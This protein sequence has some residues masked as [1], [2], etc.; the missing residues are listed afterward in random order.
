MGDE[1]EE[2]KLVERNAQGKVKQKVYSCLA[3]AACKRE[4]KQCSSSDSLSC[5]KLLWSF[6]LTKAVV[7]I[8]V[9]I[10]DARHPK[11]YENMSVK[12]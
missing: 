5:S 4:T 6:F 11:R 8:P 9:L 12:N 2:G 3:L 10:R 1:D 7:V